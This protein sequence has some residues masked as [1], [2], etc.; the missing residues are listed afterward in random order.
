M[1]SSIRIP[2][3]V[4]LFAGWFVLL[5]AGWIL[6]VALVEWMISGKLL[7]DFPEES[8]NSTLLRLL[9][10]S[11]FLGTAFLLVCGA[12]ILLFAVTRKWPSFIYAT[13]LFAV[14]LVNVFIAIAVGFNLAKGDAA[15]G[16]LIGGFAV[17]VVAGG[18]FEH[19][20]ERHFPE[21]RGGP[22]IS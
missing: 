18:L 21:P 16:N 15:A 4:R 10:V 7:P 19:V 11:L 12:L 5:E 17:L 3:W 8:G 20:R 14:V 2:H 9:L 13:G 1:S 22:S 6:V